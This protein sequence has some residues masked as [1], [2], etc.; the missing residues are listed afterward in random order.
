[1]RAMHALYLVIPALAVG[2]IAYRYYS[3]FIAAK[4]MSLDDAR[5]TPAQRSTTA[6]TTI[7]PR[8]GCCSAIISR[9]SPA[10]GR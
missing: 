5:K 2:V 9:P 10:P 1:M 7:R 6:P 4:V 3:A 8:G